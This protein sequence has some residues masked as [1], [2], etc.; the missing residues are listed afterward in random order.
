MEGFKRGTLEGEGFLYNPFTNSDI[1]GGPTQLAMTPVMQNDL[2][3]GADD[4]AIPHMARAYTAPGGPRAAG[5]G[6]VPVPPRLQQSSSLNMDMARL[7][8]FLGI[9]AAALYFTVP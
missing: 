3:V 2:P 5:S 8:I 9:L 6:A 7:G 4:S 1:W